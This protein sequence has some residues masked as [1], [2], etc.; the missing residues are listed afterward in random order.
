MLSS[1]L[2][3]VQRAFSDGQLF[4]FPPSLIENVIATEINIGGDR[5][6][7]AKSS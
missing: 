2:L 3:V 1:F 4:V 5:P 6:I 7:G